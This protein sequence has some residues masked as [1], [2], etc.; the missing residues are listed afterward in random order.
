MHVLCG[1]VVCEELLCLVCVCERGSCGCKVHFG[2]SSVTIKV[3]VGCSVGYCVLKDVRV[4]VGWRRGVMVDGD[5]CGWW[6]VLKEVLGVQMSMG[7]WY[8]LGVVWL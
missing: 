6:C 7:V 1:S 4:V 5:D 3:R 2:G 8:R